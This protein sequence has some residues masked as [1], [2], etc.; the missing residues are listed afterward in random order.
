MLF[1]SSPKPSPKSEPK[2]EPKSSPKPDASPKS[3]PGTAKKSD[4]GTSAADD[5]KKKAFTDAK[6][7]NGESGS[8][9][10]TSGS[11]TGAKS[12]GGGT[13][14]EFG[15]YHELIHD[16]FFSQWEQPT[17]IFEQDKSF[18]CTVKIHIGRDGTIKSS[19]IVKSS[20]NPIMDQSVQAA[21]GRVTKIED[22][23]STRLNSSHEW[24]SRM[25]SSA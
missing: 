8:G 22:R 16:R 9:G 13:A 10:A 25:P 20:G 6:A 17:S 1:R 14:S 19:E 18:V 5:A 11:G 15:W 21:L 7:G 3:S 24:I 12:G 4:S 2:A 23:K